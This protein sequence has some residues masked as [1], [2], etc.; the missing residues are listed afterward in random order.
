[1][2][3]A[4]KS[5]FKRLAIVLIASAIPLAVL[6][7]NLYALHHWLDIRYL[8][9]NGIATEAVVVSKDSN[10]LPRNS[11]YR[12][13]LRYSAKS[14]DE[15]SATLTTEQTVDEGLY[16]RRSA[17]DNVA[18]YYAPDRP[19]RVHVHGNDIYLKH[20]L[21]ALVGDVLL[22]IAALCVFWMTRRRGTVR[23]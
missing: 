20:I 4:A 5:L 13:T 22:A 23:L 6:G 2:I 18:V 1:V 19:E 12:I 17:G 16:K 3:A 8:E 10:E 21:Y 15:H 14:R 7:L 9:K 11:T